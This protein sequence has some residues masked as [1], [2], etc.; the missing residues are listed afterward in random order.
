M[1]ATIVSHNIN[2]MKI[3]L[4]FKKALFISAVALVSV[5]SFSQS[6]SYTIEENNP[7][8]KNLAVY[9]NPFN[10]QAY[11]PD[12]SIGVD[13]Q[14]NYLLNKKFQIDIDYRKAWTDA[15]IGVFAPKG[16]SKA[17]QFQMGGCF[18]L[19][20]K[21]KTIRNKVILSSTNI[22][23]YTLTSSISV[24]AEARRIVALRGGFQYFHNNYKIH[25]DITKA[26]GASDIQAKDKNGNLYYVFDNTT[27]ETVNY[28]VNSYGLYAGFDFKTIR[29]LVIST[30]N[31]GT[32]RTKKINNF[33][34]DVLFAPGMI[35]TLKPNLHQ[36]NFAN[37]D[38][39]IS[40]NK[41]KVL[42]WRLGWQ[43]VFNTAV[44]FNMKTE[45][46]QQPGPA[47]EN[48]WFI[49]FGIGLNF[50]LKIKLFDKTKTAS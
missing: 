45:L 16:L 28:T 22:G 1:Q 3:K 18:N 14:V 42:G 20:N 32:K 26:A 33:Y 43:Y 6:V 31:Y 46:G 40:E 29:D 15:G 9:V 8:R 36:S 19:I 30:T 35:Y 47:S 37:T 11:L 34:L 50:G 24:P 38:I 17:S 13:A 25:N 5:K 49:T 41:R 39:N 48:Q 7:D 23:R 21:R 12:I 10:A 2:N 4:I 44:G 27:F